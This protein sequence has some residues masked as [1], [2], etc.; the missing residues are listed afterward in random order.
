MT[1]AAAQAEWRRLHSPLLK[2]FPWTMPDGWEADTT[3]DPAAG[4]VVGDTRPRLLLLFGA[5]GLILLIAC[6]NVANLM[7]AR[8]TSRER[9]MAIRGALGA[10]ARR[11]IRQLLVESVL[12]GLWRALSDSC[13][14]R[15]S[16]RALTRLLPA[17][18]PRIADIALHWHVFLFAA[19]ASVLTGVLFG[20]VPAIRMASPDLQEV[21]AFGRATALRERLRRRGSRRCW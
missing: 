10:S 2:L 4:F 9:E 8:A 16:L 20:L 6:A 19:G 11:I 3:V 14:P 5:V 17:D 13:W 15:S 7:L 1:P 21:A 18:T 12:L